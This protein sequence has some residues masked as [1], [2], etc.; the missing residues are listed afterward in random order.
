ME[1]GITTIGVD[2]NKRQAVNGSFF[3]SD[4]PVDVT[5]TNPV[6]EKL[7]TEGHKSLMDYITWVGLAK[8][9]NL[10]VLSSSHHYYYDD[11]DL[12]EVTT[13]LNLKLLNHIK[14]VKDFLHTIYH[15][16]SY[17]SYFVGSFI[18]RKNQ[19]GLF[20]DTNTFEHGLSGSVDQLENGITS[21]IPFVNLMYNI[22]DSRTNRNLTKKT[23]SLL[24]EDAGLKVLDMTE[25]NG[26]TCFCAQKIK[27]SA[28]YE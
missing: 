21:R 17:K 1:N 10:I 9:P 16:I 22:M 6:L 11:E 24:L 7:A 19:F 26:L 5:G 2:V 27:T 15:M 13:V 3:L 28:G 23:V 8:D 4:Y 12:K 20:S 18:D 14:Q 25:I